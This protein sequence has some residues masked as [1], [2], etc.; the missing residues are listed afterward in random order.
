MGGQRLRGVILATLFQP[1]PQAVQIVVLQIVQQGF[2]LFTPAVLQ[3][4]V[5]IAQ[6]HF[7]FADLHPVIYPALDFADPVD[8]RIIEQAMPPSVRWGFNNP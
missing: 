5:L 1:D 4:Y 3:I 6:Q 2:L 8:I 7:D